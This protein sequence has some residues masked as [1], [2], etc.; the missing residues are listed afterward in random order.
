MRHTEL[1]TTAVVGIIG[2]MIVYTLMPHEK[3]VD[4]VEIIESPI[5]VM[6]EKKEKIVEKVV[7]KPEPELTFYETRYYSATQEEKDL[8]ARVVMSEGSILPLEGKQAIAQTIV[9]R[10]YSEKFP[11][12]IEAVVTQPYQYSM[13]DNGE[14]DRE[15]YE[16]VEAALMYNAFPEDMYYFRTGHYHTFADD[17]CQIGNTYF[18]TERDKR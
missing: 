6:L 14:P 17:Y 16:A 8:M 3:I 10:M 11:N 15:C 1:K 9:N 4:K 13:A 18:S 2:F 7:E 12:N 5:E